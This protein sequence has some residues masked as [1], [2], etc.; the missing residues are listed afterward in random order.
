LGK[1]RKLVKSYG[2]DRVVILNGGRVGKGFQKNGDCSMWE[3]FIYSWA[4]KGRSPK[5]NWTAIKKVAKDNEWYYDMGRRIT[6]LSYIDSS[7]KEAKED[8]FWAFSAARLVGFIWWAELAGTG[9]EILYRTHMGKPLED[10]K[11]S[12]GLSFRTY[13][14]GVIVL[15]NNT[16]KQKTGLP[17]S[18]GLK[19]KRLINIF[20]GLNSKGLHIKDSKLKINVPAK[21]ARIYI[22]Q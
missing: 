22:N 10:L 11:E 3:S 1:I 13:E 9:A 6:A 14:N 16:K 8:A 21:K 12:N 15:N 20:N 18:K 4:W 5:Q 17:L 7:R 19:T 2:N